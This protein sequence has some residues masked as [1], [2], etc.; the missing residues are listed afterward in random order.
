MAA[1]KFLASAVH[2][3]IV[4]LDRCPLGPELNPNMLDMLNHFVS[5]CLHNRP[6]AFQYS[7]LIRASVL[8]V[9]LEAFVLLIHMLHTSDS[10]LEGTGYHR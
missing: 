3:R 5:L 10:T 4:S 2:L 8:D 6:N 7:P 1:A 9:I